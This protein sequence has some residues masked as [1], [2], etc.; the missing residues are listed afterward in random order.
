MNIQVL[1]PRNRGV[2]CD[3]HPDIRLLAHYWH[4][5]HP[6]G[7][8]PGRM[9]F[10]FDE[11]PGLL[12]NLR[13]L[14]VVE[15]GEYRYRIR[16]IGKEHVKQLGYNPSGQWYEHITSRFK[17][18]IVELDL[19]RACHERGPIYRKGTTI[20]PYATDSK[21]VE[22]VHL[23]LASDGVNVDCIATLT[24]F[25]P[26]M[27]KLAGS[28][29]AARGTSGPDGMTSAFPAPSADGIAADELFMAQPGAVSGEERPTAC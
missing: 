19:A 7:C 4:Y 12:P 15:G 11:I 13:L 1:V 27:R 20:V 22:R 18:S 3:A 8:L 23:P 25:F 29:P 16:M 28:R 5:I 21:I 26:E 24:L 14:D 17:N 6:E 9:D 2:P 10:R